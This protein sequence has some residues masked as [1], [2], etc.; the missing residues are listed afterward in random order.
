MNKSTETL[1]NVLLVGGLAFGSLSMNSSSSTFKTEELLNGS[2]YLNKTIDDISEIVK[3]RNEGTITRNAN[4]ET[5]MNSKLYN[6]ECNLMS[7]EE[8]L[9]IRNTFS[10][11]IPDW[12]NEDM[13]IYNNL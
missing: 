13:D 11:F 5:L 3:Y 7:E 4:T 10:S 12:D 2:S 8:V 6:Q 9:K 1:C